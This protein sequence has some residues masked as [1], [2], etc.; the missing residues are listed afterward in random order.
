M[1]SQP[2]SVE[3]L[4]VMVFC[5]C[6]SVIDTVRLGLV[7]KLLSVRWLLICLILI[8][9]TMAPTKEDLGK[10]KTVDLQREL[11]SRGLD[12]AGRKSELV[13]RLWL[14]LQEGT[15]EKGGIQCPPEVGNHGSLQEAVGGPA[16]EKASAVPQPG[17]PKGGSDA[18]LLLTKLRVLK[19][20]QKVEQEK[21]RLEAR[22]EQ[23][24]L[25][26]Q[27]AEVGSYDESVLEPLRIKGHEVTSEDVLSSQVK[28]L[29]LPPTELR[30]FTGKIEDFRLFMRAFETR[31]ESKTKDERELLFYLEQFTQGKAKQLVRSCLHL[32]K[33][34]FAEA[35]RLLETRYGNP[36]HLI[37]S[38]V[39]RVKVWARIPPGDVEAL[40]GFVLFLTEA[41]N[42][43]SGVT[44]G[45]FEHPSTLRLIVSKV[46][47]YLQDRWLREADRLTQEGRAI[48]FADLVEFLTAE[49]RVKKSPLFGARPTDCSRHESHGP[50]QRF[51]VNTAKV[52][53][54]VQPGQGRQQHCLYCNN[55]HFLDQCRQLVQRPWEERRAFMFANQLC[56]GCLRRGHRARSCRG[57]L[58]CAVCGE[59]HPTV[60]H[61]VGGDLQ[62]PSAAGRSPVRP[63][64]QR[65]GIP[66]VEIGGSRPRVSAVS[67]SGAVAA[68]PPAVTAPPGGVV[69]PPGGAEV[70]PPSGIGGSA[71]VSA[72]LG[73]DGVGRTALPVVAVRLRGPT[74]VEVVTNGF[75][76]PG[77][78][79]SF[80]TTSLA[81]RLGVRM[82]S[83]S[84]SIETLGSERRVVS[85]S[86]APGLEV[87]E[88]NGDDFYPL[89]PLLTVA[90]LPITH[91]DR[92][93]SSELGDA[94]YLRD[95]QLCEVDT[96]VELLLGSNCA[97]LI[98][99][100]EVRCPPPGVEGLCAV[101]TCLGWYVMGCV[102]GTTGSRGRLTVNFLR[103][104]DTCTS[105]QDLG[106][107]VHKRMYEQDFKDLSDDRECFSIED[108]EWIDDVRSSMKRDAEGHFEVPL[109][110]IEFSELPDSYQTARRRLLSLQKRFQADP[111]YFGEYRR[112][113][114]SLVDDGYAV[115]VSD[116]T[117][118]P[119]WYL[120]HHGVMETE[121]GKVRVVFDCAAKSHGVCLN[122]LLRRGPIL[123]NSLLG[124]LC[125]F[126]EGPVAFTCDVRSMYHRVHV[127]NADSNLLRFLWFR[128][129]DPDGQIQIFRMRSHVFGAVSSGSVASLALAY[130]A[131][132]G[133]TCFPEAADVILRNT[134][135]DDAL[136]AT[137]TVQDAVKV[138]RD[139]KELCAAGS[140]NMTKFSSNSPEFLRQIP[141]EDRGKNVKDLDLDRDSLGSERALGL[142]WSMDTDMFFFQ[143]S[144]NR[145]PM[146]RRGLL[147]TVSSIFDPLGIVAPVTL[148]GRILLQKLC[149]LSYGWDD[150]LPDVLQEEWQEWL[151]R[152]SE[153]DRVHL[154]RCILG[155]PCNVTSTQLHVFAD[156]SETGYSAVAYLRREV[157]TSGGGTERFVSFLLGK[158]LVN[159]IRFVTVPRLELAAAVLAV[160]LRRL[161]TRE[162]DIEF[163]TVHMWTD[164]MVVLSYVRNRTTRFK[165]YVANRLSYIHDGSNVAEWAYVP[166]K[167]NPA[168]IG[169]RGCPPTG[170]DTWLHGPEFLGG[171]VG[172]WP[173]EPA[174][175]VTVPECEIKSSL[176]AAVSVVP[177]A[178]NPCDVLITYFSSFFR[179]KRAV[180]W[181]LK[182]ADALRDGSYRRWCLTKRRGLRRRKYEGETTL[183][184][185]DISVAEHA[186]LR[187]VQKD[188]TEFPG[189]D[190]A[191]GPVEVR[192]GSRL[193]ALR[194]TMLDGLLVVGG[195]LSRSNCLS[196]GAKHPVILPRRSHVTGL[197]IRD[198]H[199]SVGHE[200]RDHT[201][202]RLRQRYWIIGAGP[203]IRRM[204]RSCVV[205]RKAN[206]RP[207]HQLMADLP[208]ERITAEAPAFSSVLLDVFGPIIVKTGRVERKRYGLMCVCIVTRAVHVEIL[209]S[210][211]TDS[212]INAIR[213]ICARR[214]PIHQVRSDMGTNLAGADR[215]LREA[216]SGDRHAELQRASLKQGIEWQFNPPTASHFAGGVERQIRTFRK[217]W[218]SMPMQQSLDDESLRTLFCEIES[219]MNSRPLTYMSTTTG[220]VEPLT[221]GHLL[222]LRGAA[223]PIPGPFN[224]A[225]SMSR[226]R[227][228]HVQYLAEQFWSRW[229]K[230]YVLS[231]QSRQKWK[232]EVRNLKP[233]DI[234][235]LVDR[236]TQRGRWQMGRIQQVFPSPDGLV[237]K[238]VVR[239][240]VSSY[241]RPIHK[242]ILISS[243]TDLD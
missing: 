166:S 222:F 138:A 101:R 48:H 64:G 184:V 213:R 188:L 40:D 87:G 234:V 147:S 114:E 120:P 178:G 192:K 76:D 187:Y 143:F 141:A 210:L 31:I 220:E 186:V 82:E 21:L 134:Y 212:L 71:V 61:R 2:P 95:V 70:L 221:P 14:A 50:S 167:V 56:F 208:R 83:T 112:V 131:E 144:D 123:T 39:E 106:E 194:P 228:R 130:C 150:P 13:D 159:P 66:P 118:D 34:G 32:Q 214:G 93:R 156:A 45:E 74:G 42:A 49:V 119:V 68:P 232:K 111:A 85:T 67:R 200:G 7:Y 20:K 3:V 240:S 174:I 86:L 104:Q 236:D 10:L 136:C 11:E 217:I 243:E 80:V 204:I 181:Y 211:R 165:T 137:D 201:F 108:Q 230:E 60:M 151:V 173:S 109:P 148:P 205:C 97:A 129:H 62:G 44:L 225:D 8:L 23:L 158:S 189:G 33:G 55:A 152:A 175:H 202:W 206:A 226:R 179:L 26:L 176:V 198:A 78:S 52:S 4:R 162:L 47:T 88:L 218:R 177:G 24:Q 163:D 128:N 73:L 233:G 191:D 22:S 219:V 207:L 51:K 90:N 196:Q 185:S 99:A 116:E 77:S 98:V 46:P 103:V 6:A 79:G 154:S 29:L 132:E 81:Q 161:L 140:F 229:R 168:D 110:K 172:L 27:L 135:V 53:D 12:S 190:C 63:R 231:L 171:E 155:P 94:A 117:D 180:A 96:P 215:E 223:G 122:D 182:F 65:V 227:W 38:Y 127:P 59:R 241:L 203:E 160:R 142:K 125:R 41:K 133:R 1:F 164:S 91:N 17:E 224:E 57:P 197:V 75:F 239:T 153:M 238:A 199:E 124:V 157:R 30:P 5:N 242:M 19:E 69:L 216:F 183:T 195:R 72:G 36:I 9:S 54:S 92:C 84:V 170:L 169:S 149:A 145:K 100:R 209:D 15:E 18:R 126:R 139:L 113:I 193:S 115:P 58:T 43:M 235:L 105:E 89:P 102:Q 28:H 37:D 146:T 237:R 25:E 35:K 107:C 16:D 121:K